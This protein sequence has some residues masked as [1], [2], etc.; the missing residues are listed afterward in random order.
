MKST[1]LLLLP[2][3]TKRSIG[4]LTMC[5]TDVTLRIVNFFL[6]FKQISVQP[7]LFVVPPSLFVDFEFTFGFESS[8]EISM[9]L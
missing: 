4:F 3:P 6:Y 9:D 8:D 5:K 7:S 1:T 2:V